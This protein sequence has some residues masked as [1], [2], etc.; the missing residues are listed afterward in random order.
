ML[1]A[2]NTNGTFVTEIPEI[3]ERFLL[4][5][6]FCLS[7]ELLPTTFGAISLVLFLLQSSDQL[8]G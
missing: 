6:N 4:L 8:Q 2:E 7:L 1:N 3:R 5:L